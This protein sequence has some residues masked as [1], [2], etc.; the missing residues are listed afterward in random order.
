MLNDL[1]KKIYQA[2]VEKGFYEDNQEVI[3]FME[4]HGATKQ[5]IE[6]VKKAVVGQRL[7]LITSEIAEALEGNRK[8]RNAK[9]ESKSYYDGLADNEMFNHEFEKYIKDTTEDEMADA[10][11]R[12]L[13]Y[14]GAYGIDIDFHVKQKLRY[15][16][17][18]PHKHGKTY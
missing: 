18:R 6:T 8:D 17:L 15:N 4:S 11:I 7:M 16:S 12:I 13:D 14:A 10:L 2:N 1:A 3:K 9:I 5:M